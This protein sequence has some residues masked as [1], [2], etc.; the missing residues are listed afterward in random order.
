LF[1]LLCAHH[2][3]LSDRSRSSRFLL[4]AFL[5]LF[6]GLLCLMKSTNTMLIGLLMALVVFDRLRNRRYLDLACNLGGVTV[7]ACLL[8]ILAG[9]KVCHFPQFMRGAMI[10][11]SSYNEALALP[12]QTQLIYLGLVAIALFALANALRLW[13]FRLYQF[14]LPVTVFEAACLFIAWKHGYVRHGGFIFWLFV[15]S[16]SPLLFLAHEKPL[17]GNSSQAPAQPSL[18]RR[19]L[20]RRGVSLIGPLA[21]L[22]TATLVCAVWA[23]RFDPGN[24]EFASYGSLG[25][26]LSAPVNRIRSNIAGLCDCRHRRQALELALQ[27]NRS[28]AALPE[29]KKAVDDATIDQF[30]YLPGVPLLNDLHYTPRPMPISFIACNDFLMRRNAEFY[31]DASTAP[32]F[33][34]ASIGQIDGRFAPQD[35]ALA[36]LELLGHYQPL[37]AEQGFVLLKRAASQPGLGRQLRDSRTVAWGESIPLP[38]ADGKFIWCTAD[39]RFSLLGRA[40]SFFYQSAQM[41]IV[42]ESQG[43]E[44][45]AVRFLPC[46]AHTGFLARP[47]IFNT[48]DLLAAY[49][50]RAEPASWRTPQFDRF[51]F[52]ANAKDQDCF[53]PAINVSFWTIEPLK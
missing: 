2:L 9:Q 49:G 28:A 26:A 25:A 47:L 20:L 4:D 3:L 37:L 39:I 36:L 50:V 40:R 51:R 48:V 6:M 8:W 43:R 35:D 53:Q 1:I 42:L 23:C 17:L 11:S 12:A 32:A 10:F 52:V 16:A 18:G 15:I 22:L 29:V 21:L 27:H 34:L 13:Q 14:R 45:G 5:C 19:F 46:A 7:V 30:G 31:R 44:L 41:F 24:K 33:V 38:S